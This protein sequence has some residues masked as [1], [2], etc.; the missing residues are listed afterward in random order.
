MKSVLTIM[1]FLFVVPAKAQQPASSYWLALQMPVQVSKK[2]QWHNDAGYRT[3][4]NQAAAQ[5]YLY[6]TGLRL[7]FTKTLSAAAGAAF[8]Y[9]RTSPVKTSHEFGKEH[10]GW[11]ELNWQ[12]QINKKL[13]GQLRL[14]T[15]ERF[16]YATA[17]SSS[18]YGFR[19]RL[20]GAL[21]Q[22]L[23][24]RWS[25]QVADEYMR[26][27]ASGEFSFNQNRVSAAFIYTCSNLQLLAG[28][29]RLKTSAAL[30]HI[31][32]FTIQK[33]LSF[34]ANVNNSNKK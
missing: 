23:S 10:R 15:E 32:Q 34:N 17:E 16:F 28:Y 2:W 20:R 13:Q 4:G 22:Y 11:Q 19:I 21:T 30:Q 14:R 26:Q 18:S 27:A 33:N 9:T 24:S 3:L 8:F 6:R 12:P 31:V 5:Q 1:F 25:I 7:M 29:M